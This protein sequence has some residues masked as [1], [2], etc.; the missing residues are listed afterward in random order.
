MPQKAPRRLHAPPDP[1]TSVQFSGKLRHPHLPV[2]AVPELC[3][4]SPPPVH[5]GSGDRQKLQSSAFLILFL[6]LFFTCF[7]RSFFVARIAQSLHFH[8]KLSAKEKGIT[9]R[10]GTRT[11]AACQGSPGDGLHN[12]RFFPNGNRDREAL[13]AAACPALRTQ[14]VPGSKEP[15][16]CKLGQTALGSDAKK[17]ARPSVRALPTRPA[18]RAA[19]P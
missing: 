2:H 10:K 13:V 19:R 18:E 16:G 8:A 3:L 14:G 12:L 6:R 7:L 11:F 17:D 5:A 1:S 4:Q 9:A 15:G